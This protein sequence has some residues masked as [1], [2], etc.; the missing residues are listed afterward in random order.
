MAS[1]LNQRVEHKDSDNQYRSSEI[2]DCELWTHKRWACDKDI[3]NAT[4]FC[5]SQEGCIKNCHTHH[6][7][8]FKRHTKYSR[9]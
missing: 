2:S 5:F 7:R 4:T 1:L 9:L 6:I 8:D 3:C